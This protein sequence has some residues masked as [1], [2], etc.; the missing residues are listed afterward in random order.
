MRNI[1]HD[2]PDETSQIILS[3]LRD[4]MGEDSCILI[5]EMVLPNKGTNFQ[6][7]Q[8]DF[9]MMA[10]LSAMERTQKQWMKLL[11]SAGLKVANTYTY[12][13]SLQDSIL[14]CVKK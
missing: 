10:A 8:L 13:E 4:A 11:D 14:V 3:H 12:T 2:W 9:T 6:A 7:M 5:D 1:L